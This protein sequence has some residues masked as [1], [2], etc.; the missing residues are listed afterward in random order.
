MAAIKKQMDHISYIKQVKREIVDR[1]LAEDEEERL[2]MERANQ[3]ETA[4]EKIAKALKNLDLL[5]EDS[6]DEEQSVHSDSSGAS[7][8]VSSVGSRLASQKHLKHIDDIMASSESEEEG[9][10]TDIEE[11]SD[12]DGLMRL[13]PAPSGKNKNLTAANL[14]ELNEM[15]AMSQPAAYG[16]LSDVL[17]NAT[18]AREPAGAAAPVSTSQLFECYRY[19]DPTEQLADEMDLAVSTVGVHF[20]HADG[21][22][23]ICCFP[24]KSIKKIW[25]DPPSDDPDDLD[26]FHM[27]VVGADNPV[28]CECMEWSKIEDAVAKFRGQAANE[29]ALQVPNQKVVL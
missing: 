14:K 6:S 24:W 4:E 13:L 5:G 18:T 16:E 19:D 9:A 29:A 3:K 26:L 22:L 2:E 17:A 8:V 12:E 1:Q 25:A 11:G 28:T 10:E 23:E 20:K 7:S 15:S 27:E 21:G